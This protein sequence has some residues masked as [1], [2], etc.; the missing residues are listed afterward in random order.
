MRIRGGGRV[1]P[2]TT[3]EN[4]EQQECVIKKG[5]FFAKLDFYRRRA[6]GQGSGQ[7]TV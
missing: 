7:Q 3:I 4:D 1:P 6:L 2:N 5:Y